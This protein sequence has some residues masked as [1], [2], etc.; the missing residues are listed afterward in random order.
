MGENIPIHKVGVVVVMRQHGQLHTL[1]VRPNAKNPCE[2]APLVPP[3]GTRQYLDD[4]GIWKDAR[5]VEDAKAHADEKWV[6]EQF[7]DTAQRELL[8]EAGIGHELISR[9]GGLQMMGARDYIALHKPAEAREAPYRIHWFLL[10][11]K[12]EDIPALEKP[13]DAAETG[14]F[15]LKQMEIEAAR[16]AARPGYVAIVKEAMEIVNRKS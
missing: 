14:W 16:G 1:L 6:W 7:S 5:T 11:L 9:R 12:P 8:E 13:N 15:T 3:R 10:E 4:D 2:T